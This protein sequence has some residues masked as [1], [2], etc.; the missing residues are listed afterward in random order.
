MLSQVTSPAELVNRDVADYLDSNTCQHG[1]LPSEPCL[2]CAAAKRLAARRP[3]ESS[4]FWAWHLVF[5]C[6]R[7]WA[8]SWPRF[9]AWRKTEV[10]EI[11]GDG[12][13]TLC[14]MGIA[15]WALAMVFGIA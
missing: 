7:C 15:F 3:P 1:R 14:V 8:Q 12:I 6:Y 11:L 13:M 9:R 10:G 5:G 2:G 4:G